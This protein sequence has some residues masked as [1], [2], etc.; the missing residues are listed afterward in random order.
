MY[1]DNI[2]SAKNEEEL[3]TLIQALRIYSEDIGMELGI[4]KCAVLVMKSGKREMTEGIEL[5]NQEKTRTGRE[6]ETY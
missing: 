3:E 1:M 2:L 4:E 5:P 6:K